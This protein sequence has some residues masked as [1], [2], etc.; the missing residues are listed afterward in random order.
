MELRQDDVCECAG[1]RVSTKQTEVQGGRCFLLRAALSGA[2]MVV[3]PY[4]LGPQS[5]QSL[6][7]ICVLS[8]SH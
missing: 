7:L 4:P 2:A 5:S 1:C 3:L 6:R 8:L